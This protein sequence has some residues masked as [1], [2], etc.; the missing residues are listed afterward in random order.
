MNINVPQPDSRLV[1]TGLDVVDLTRFRGALQRHP[2]LR[3]RL[4]SPEE[5]AYADGR[6][7]PVV[8]LAARFAAKEAV[9]KLLGTGVTS[10]K[11]ICVESQGGA[12]SVRLLGRA[13]QRADTLRL[14]PVALSLSHTATIAMAGAVALILE[15]KESW[16]AV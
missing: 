16:E 6:R 3:E 9:G 8:H 13:A 5:L 4:F 12:P 7:D 14:G 10:W 11:D 15:N 2:R 1:L